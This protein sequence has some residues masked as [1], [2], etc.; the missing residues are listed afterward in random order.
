VTLRFDVHVHSARSVAGSLPAEHLIRR[1]EEV[2]LDGIVLTEIGERWTER[3]LVNLRQRTETRLIVLSAEFLIVED[4]NL[5]AYGFSGRLPPLDSLETAVGRIRAEGGAA[6][7]AYPFDDGAPPLERLVEIGVQGV[8]VF[9]A[10]GE[11][12]TD[13]QLDRVRR[14]GLATVAGSGFRGGAG[15]AVG[16]CHTLVDTDV[17]TGRDLAMAIKLGRTRAVFGPPSAHPAPGTVVQGDIAANR[18]ARS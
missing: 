12:P 9:S 6:V 8:E 5:L 3:E 18:A 1:A 17:R 14:L 11:L 4:V 16:D 15:V 13:E 7:V 2:G 10:N